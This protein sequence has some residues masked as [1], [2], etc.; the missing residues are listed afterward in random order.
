MKIPM[1]LSVNQMFHTNGREVGK[2]NTFLAA[3]ARLFRNA[4]AVYTLIVYAVFL[5]AYN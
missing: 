1:Q 5:Y 4:K 3:R 2:T